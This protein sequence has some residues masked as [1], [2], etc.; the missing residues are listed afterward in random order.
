M[1]RVSGNRHPVAKVGDAPTEAPER[2]N[3]LPKR[4]FKLLRQRR[5]GFVQ[6]PQEGLELEQTHAERRESDAGL[7]GQAG[8]EDAPGAE[9][10]E[11]D[12][13]ASARQADVDAAVEALSKQFPDR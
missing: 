6:P 1:P 10:P 13:A 8:V 2:H 5:R 9:G 7:E 11:P 4:R 3:H 12:A